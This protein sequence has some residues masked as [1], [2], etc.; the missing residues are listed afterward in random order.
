M[1]TKDSLHSCTQMQY[2][3]PLLPP[4]THSPCPA[5]LCLSCPATCVY[6]KHHAV[7]ADK[8]PI[9][10][11]GPSTFPNWG[12]LHPVPGPSAQPTINSRAGESLRLAVATR[13]CMF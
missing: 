2:K 4:V 12:L 1:G 7:A 13:P 8:P 11:C 3:H 6:Y 9:R 5:L 10:V